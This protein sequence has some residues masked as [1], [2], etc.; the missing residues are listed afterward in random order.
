MMRTIVSIGAHSGS[1]HWAWKFRFGIDAGDAISGEAREDEKKK[2]NAINGHEAVF[3]R[4]SPGEKNSGR[5]PPTLGAV[6]RVIGFATYLLRVHDA[7][8]RR[9]V[10][11]GDVPLDPALDYEE[12]SLRRAR[13]GVKRVS[14][15]SAFG[16][17]PR[18]H[19]GESAVRSDAREFGAERRIHSPCG[20]CPPQ[21]PR[22]RAS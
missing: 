3:A 18:V 5:L 7:A 1:P 8:S 4:R 15:A 16:C 12:S 20:A 22:R 6:R 14:V 10:V 21:P 11:R 19:T 13:V 9:E 2:K 17:V